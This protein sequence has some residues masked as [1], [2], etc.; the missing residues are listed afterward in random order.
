MH[1]SALRTSFPHLVVFPISRAMLPTS[2]KENQRV[3][4]SPSLP[5]VFFV[6]GGN[7]DRGDL[8]RNDNHSRK[9]LGEEVIIRSPSRHFRAFFPH[10]KTYTWEVAKND[11]SRVALKKVR[12]MF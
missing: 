6:K 3:G 7:N 4:I 10:L 8:L 12:G 1:C 2:S 9:Q 11:V 5:I